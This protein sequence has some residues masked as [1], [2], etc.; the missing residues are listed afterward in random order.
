MY[1]CNDSNI[2]VMI[3]SE[4]SKHKL[5]SRVSI[6]IHKPFIVVLVLARN[7]SYRV[8]SHLSHFFWHDSK[9]ILGVMHLLYYTKVT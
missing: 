1:T 7:Y 8:R 3:R 5:Q 4:Q 9:F 2:Y 6:K